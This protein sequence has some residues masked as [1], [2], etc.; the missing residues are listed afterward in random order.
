MVCIIDLP[1]QNTSKRRTCNEHFLILATVE[2]RAAYIAWESPL[3]RAFAATACIGLLMTMLVLCLMVSNSNQ[4][5]FKASSPIFLLFILVGI[6]IGYASTFLYIGEPTDATC[7]LQPWF[8]TYA[9]SITQSAIITKTWRI[10]RIFGNSKLMSSKRLHTGV[11]LRNMFIAALL[12]SVILIVWTILDPPKP[13]AFFINENE[14]YLECSSNQGP[15]YHGILIGFN[16]ALLLF[17][18]WLAS[19]TRHVDFKHREGFW[20]TAIVN[21]TFYWAAC[22]VR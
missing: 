2:A 15:I 14:A 6:M 18:C 19:K 22:A 5:V 12:Q 11:L 10:Y 16:G 1:K 3:G 17:G 21:N 13:T 8:L 7:I 9:F 4:D 20:I